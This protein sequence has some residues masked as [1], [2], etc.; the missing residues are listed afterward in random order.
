MVKIPESPSEHYF[1]DMNWS[2]DDNCEL[3]SSVMSGLAKDIYVK[4]YFGVNSLA[5]TNCNL[6][7]MFE[8]NSNQVVFD[9]YNAFYT[10]QFMGILIRESTIEELRSLKSLAPRMKDVL[11]ELSKEKKIADGYSIML[12]DFFHHEADCRQFTGLFL[13]LVDDSKYNG[14][15]LNHCVV[16]MI[17]IGIGYPFEIR[18]IQGLGGDRPAEFYKKTGR[19]FDEVLVRRLI[20]AIG[21]NMLF[22]SNDPKRKVPKI[23]F[24]TRLNNA[25]MP[26]SYVKNPKTG[27]TEMIV[28]LRHG[29]R[30][31]DYMTRTC[32]LQRI[33]EKVRKEES[34][35]YVRHKFFAPYARKA[36]QMQKI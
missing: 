36:L 13:N 1:K 35:E 20:E 30:P 19:H 25:H 17:G 14:C 16:G 24:E 2:T 22:E 27:E 4:G 26:G 28:K 29:G 33:R 7:K 31:L 23:T 32:K 11:I 8:E 10:K 6:S 5:G 34:I 21:C 18:H 15:S 12:S 3:I 9:Y